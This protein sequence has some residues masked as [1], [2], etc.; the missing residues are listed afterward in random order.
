MRGVGGDDRVAL[1]ALAPVGE[2]GAHQHQPRQLALR[3]GGRLQRHGR[4]PRHLGQDLLQL[5]H[6]LE[7][8][9]RALVLLMR[10]QVRE[11]RAVRAT[12]S[13]TRGLYFIVHEPSG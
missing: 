4:Q 1:L 3:A 2:V 5:P 13:L 11:A 10:V 7:R 9:L 8:A 12:R 6:Q